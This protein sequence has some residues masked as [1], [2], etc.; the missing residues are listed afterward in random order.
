MQKIV[1]I[2]DNL[3][4]GEYEYNDNIENFQISI[5]NNNIIANVEDFISFK[6]KNVVTLINDKSYL[7][8]S[9]NLKI[10]ML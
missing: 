3:I 8:K 10:N 5:G 4:V 7:L 9:N 2:I 1:L 6:I